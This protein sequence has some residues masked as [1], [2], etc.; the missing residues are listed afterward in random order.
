VERLGVHAVQARAIDGRARRQRRRQ[1]AGDLEVLARLA[2]GAGR[3]RV[4]AGA[5]R[6]LEGAGVVAGE[7]EVVG[8]AA[9]HRRIIGGAHEHG[10]GARVPAAPL[11]RA[12]GGVGGLANLVVREA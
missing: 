4:P 3:V 1:R 6:P 10:G 2:I 9:P 7:L 11:V 12:D 8:Q 5:L